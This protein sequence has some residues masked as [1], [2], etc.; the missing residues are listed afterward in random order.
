MDGIQRVGWCWRPDLRA[1]LGVPRR[2][3]P[4]GRRWRLFV[5]LSVVAGSFTVDPVA[6]GFVDNTLLTS[7]VAPVPVVA[8]VP[9]PTTLTLVGIGLAVARHRRRRRAF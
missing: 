4:A 9:E 5:V 7:A 6:Y 2:H 3:A 8:S 1:H